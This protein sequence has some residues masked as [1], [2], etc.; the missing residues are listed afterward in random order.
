MLFQSAEDRS[1]QCGGERGVALLIVLLVT[2]LLIALIFEFSYATRISLNNAINFRDSQRAYFLAQTGINAFKANGAKLRELIPQAK[3]RPVPGIAE[4]DTV[5]MVKW[6]DESGKIKINDIKKDTAS[7][8]PR[9]NPGPTLI[10]ARTLFETVKGIDTGVLDRIADPQSDVS[11]MTLLSGIR[12][13]MNQEDFG[14]V[15]GSLT[16]APVSQAKL[17]I[18]INSASPDVLQSLGVDAASAQRIADDAKNT[19][20]TAQDLNSTGR[21]ASLANI[22]V[23]KLNLFTYLKT[24][25]SG[26]YRVYAYATV[27]GYTKTVEAI[28]NGSAVYYWQA[29]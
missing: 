28:L 19:P 15:A 5:I 25:S 4:G 24:D 14:K 12:Q 2:A 26:Y 21:L 29:L 10:V 6:E 17:S 8:D 22:Y 3:W 1:K 7:L 13:Y 16:T 27:G 20:Y 18:N 9:T 23:N 11:N